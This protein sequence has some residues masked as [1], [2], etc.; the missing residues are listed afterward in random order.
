M[1]LLQIFPPALFV[2]IYTLCRM[3]AVRFAFPPILV[4]SKG[5]GSL[6]GLAALV[7]RVLSQILLL[8]QLQSIAFIGLFCPV[9]LVFNILF[10]LILNPFL[11]RHFRTDG[12]DP[13]RT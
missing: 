7:S 3:T 8:P 12:R 1:T 6:D 9:S 5:P 4:L 13:S 10:T 2:A 11:L